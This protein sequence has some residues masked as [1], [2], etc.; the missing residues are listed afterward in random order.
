MGTT[1]LFQVGITK[2][3]SVVIFNDP[4][5]SSDRY[6]SRGSKRKKKQHADVE[7]KKLG[8]MEQF[9]FS[10]LPIK[11]VH[12]NLKDGLNDGQNFNP[13]CVES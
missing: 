3:V 10:Y 5:M 6:N 7:K 12:L 8:E 13:K 4:T 1:H 2:N 11:N 9:F